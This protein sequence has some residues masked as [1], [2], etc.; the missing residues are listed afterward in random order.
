HPALEIE[1]CASGGGR[2]DYGILQRTDR[3]WTSDNNDARHRHSIMT[4]AARFFP[5]SVLGNHVG[6]KQCHITGRVFDMAFR[7]GTAIFGHMGMELDLAKESE[8]D[9]TILAKAIALHKRHR[10]LIHDGA[11]HTLPTPNFATAYGCVSTDRTEALFACAQIDMLRYNRPPRQKFAGLDA[12]KLY[13]IRLVWPPANPSISHPSIVDECN[14][15]G[16][17]SEFTGGALMRHGIQ[18]PLTMPDTC[19]IYYLEAQP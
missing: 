19:L 4:G 11:Y 9:R 15:M 2:A 18:M 8:A 3:I 6:P 16:T 1:S 13:R 7:A 12:S 5:L 17:G 14:L 10:D